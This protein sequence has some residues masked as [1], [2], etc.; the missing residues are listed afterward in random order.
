M[1]QTM[2][3][4][5]TM[6][7]KVE[8]NQFVAL[9]ERSPERHIAVD[10]EAVAMAQREPRPVGIT[11]MANADDGAIVHDGVDRSKWWRYFDAQF[12]FLDP[13]PVARAN[14]PMLATIRAPRKIHPPESEARNRKA[15]DYIVTDHKWRDRAIKW[16]G[17]RPWQKVTLTLNY[18]PPHSRNMQNLFSENSKLC[19]IH[20]QSSR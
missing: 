5:L 19:S 10:R 12:A 4:I 14:V 17:A 9:A 8:Q 11:V 18:P 20:Q 2:R 16:L 7:A 13:L 3:L 6:I 1:I 15:R